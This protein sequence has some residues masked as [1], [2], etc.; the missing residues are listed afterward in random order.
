[1]LR[2]DDLALP[3]DWPSGAYVVRAH[4]PAEIPATVPINDAVGAVAM[5]VVSFLV[6]AQTAAA[7]VKAEMGI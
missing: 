2:L 1:M 4:M 7:A 5:G 3:E 6:S